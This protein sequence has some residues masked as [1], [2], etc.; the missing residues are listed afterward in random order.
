[1]PTAKIVGSWKAMMTGVVSLA[2][3]ALGA[4]LSAREA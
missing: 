1:V 3:L 2:A 4:V